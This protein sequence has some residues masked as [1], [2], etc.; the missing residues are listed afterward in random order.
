VLAAGAGKGDGALLLPA[1]GDA[2]VLMGAAAGRLIER[3]GDENSGLKAS[4]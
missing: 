4:A 1:M 2:I 3:D